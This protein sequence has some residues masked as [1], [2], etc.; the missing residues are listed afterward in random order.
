MY[1]SLVW[2]SVSQRGAYDLPIERT[3][4]LGG[5]Y[6][7]VNGNQYKKRFFQSDLKNRVLPR[8]INIYADMN[9]ERFF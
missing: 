1:I 6:K 3:K 5:D 2:S 7:I 9:K 8:N 4:V